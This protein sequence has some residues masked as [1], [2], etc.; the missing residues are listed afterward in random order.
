MPVWWHSVLTF[1]ALF[2]TWYTKY[3]DN[4]QHWKPQWNTKPWV[5]NFLKAKGHILYCGLLC[6]LNVKN[7]CKLFT[8]NLHYCVNF[9]LY[10][11]FIKL[12]SRSLKQTGRLQTDESVVLIINT[13]WIKSNFFLIPWGGE[14]CSLSAT[15]HIKTRT[16]FAYVG[17]LN[18]LLLSHSV[19]YRFKE[20]L[21]L[22]SWSMRFH[23]EIVG[24]R[25]LTSP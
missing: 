13:R 23:E 5:T 25:H 22:L 7:N 2:I 4:G 12:I 9:T 15:L 20:S 1:M 8:L 17:K 18:I 14:I 11:K 6:R 10:I 21:T 19:N 3:S 24:N 16:L